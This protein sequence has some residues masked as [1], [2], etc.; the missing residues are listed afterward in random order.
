MKRLPMSTNVF[1]TCC[2][3]CRTSSQ[4]GCFLCI[5]RQPRRT[6]CCALCAQTVCGVAEVCTLLNIPSHQDKSTRDLGG[7]GLRRSLSAFW[8]SLGRLFADDW[9]MGPAHTGANLRIKNCQGSDKGGSMRQHPEL[10]GCFRDAVLMP[11]FAN[12]EQA[13]AT[14]T[15]WSHQRSTDDMCSNRALLQFDHLVVQ[16]SPP[17]PPCVS[18]FFSRLACSRAAWVCG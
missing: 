7:F 13:F 6:A 12:H 16:D 11:R 5:A 9:R 4:A 1:W 3:Q 10:N 18:L 15:K 17:A 14:V 2:L 8:A